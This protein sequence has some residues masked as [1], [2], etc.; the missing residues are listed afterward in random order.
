MS[1]VGYIYIFRAINPG[2]SGLKK[3]NKNNNNNNNDNNNW[4]TFTL[5]IYIQNTYNQT[6][7]TSKMFLVTL[8]HL[9]AH[10]LSQSIQ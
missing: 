9:T 5:F 2:V 7:T 1:I 4:D 3:I 6:R 10:Q 8:Y